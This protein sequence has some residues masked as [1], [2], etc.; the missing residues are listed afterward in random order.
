MC[1]ILDHYQRHIQALF[2][3]RKTG[4][5][6]ASKVRKQHKKTPLR[7]KLICFDRLGCKGNTKRERESYA[8][9]AGVEVARAAV[10]PKVSC[11]CEKQSLYIDI[12][13]LLVIIIVV[14]IFQ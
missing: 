4:S 9:E 7:K 5:S 14:D 10:R 8:V 3:Q 13:V 1:T 2:C 6:R 12:D 11:S